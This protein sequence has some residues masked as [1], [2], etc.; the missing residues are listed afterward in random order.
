MTLLLFFLSPSPRIAVDE[1]S[2]ET[3]LILGDPSGTIQSLN[4]PLN[5]PRGTNTTQR[6]VCPV[7][8]RIVLSVPNVTTSAAVVDHSSCTS[9][10]IIVSDP[11]GDVSGIN[12]VQRHALYEPC[13]RTKG[14]Y[15]DVQHNRLR[16]TRET[17][18][19]VLTSTL[20]V[21]YLHSWT[22][23]GALL[24][25]TVNYRV[26]KGKKTL[27]ISKTFFPNRIQGDIKIT[28]LLKKLY[29]VVYNEY[30]GKAVFHFMRKSVKP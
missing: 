4:Y 22:M 28:K 11:Y 14:M 16:A 13:F 30:V 25:Y 9:S 7:G 24:R 27:N 5:M 12:G 26:Y 8:H 23:N 20:N 18:R 17:G 19:G 21:L 1:S 6:L 2:V 10:G 29:N 15:D 3:I